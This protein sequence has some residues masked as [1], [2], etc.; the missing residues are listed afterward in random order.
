MK[1]KQL[2]KGCTTTCSSMSERDGTD[3]RMGI[4]SIVSRR[5]ASYCQLVI[6][7]AWTRTSLGPP[8]EVA[9]F[10]LLFVVCPPLKSCFCFIRWC[11][12]LLFFLLKDFFASFFSLLFPLD[13][14][15]TTTSTAVFF[16]FPNEL[17]LCCDY[18]LEF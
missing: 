1:I 14:F 13:G 9:C 4:N 5:F 11:F 6:I 18:R 8:C 10:S 15:A 16:I 7:V 2:N 17:S 3:R 12:Y